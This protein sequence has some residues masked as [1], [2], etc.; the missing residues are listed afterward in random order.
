MIQTV[1]DKCGTTT[2]GFTSTEDLFSFEEDAGWAV[3]KKKDLCPDCQEPAINRAVK[4]QL[5]E[6]RYSFVDDSVYKLCWLQLERDLLVMTNHDSNS[7]RRAIRD[8]F[9]T[10]RSRMIEILRMQK[11]DAKAKGLAIPENKH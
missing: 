7:K 8:A 1:C 3:E 6:E 5:K 4:K 10:I 9:G 2:P 11:N